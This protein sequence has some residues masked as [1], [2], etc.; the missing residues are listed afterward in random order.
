MRVTPWLWFPAAQMR[1]GRLSIRAKT[2]SSEC[3]NFDV[4]QGKFILI[5]AVSIKPL[6]AH[7][8]N[9]NNKM[10]METRLLSTA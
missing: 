5:A 8:Q 4:N 6:Q 2:T 3:T 9:A 7:L 10:F 1:I